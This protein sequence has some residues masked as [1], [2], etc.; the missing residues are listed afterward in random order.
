LVRL[1]LVIDSEL[2]NLSL[3]AAALNGICHHLGLNEVEAYQV[4]LCI[5]EAVTN[6]IRHAYH[7][8]PDKKV[9]IE[10]S[11]EAG[12]LNIEVSD[13]GTRMSE[14]E[15]KTLLHGSELPEFE[16]EN[17]RSIPESGRGLQIIHDLM[18]DVAYIRVGKLNRLKLKKNISGSRSA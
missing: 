16:R 6:V 15:L 18:D 4:E 7:G 5:T 10:I 14:N 9:C 12:Q 11:A 8:N 17:I 13:S 2:A 3:V 1:H